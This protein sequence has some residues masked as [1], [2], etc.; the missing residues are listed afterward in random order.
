MRSLPIATA[1]MHASRVGAGWAALVWLMDKVNVVA[2][3][4][5]TT[6]GAVEAAG[7]LVWTFVG[8]VSV[9]SD[10]SSIW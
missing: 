1:M 9:E 10:A 5:S 4:T 2:V 6:K 8:D 7:M 3:E